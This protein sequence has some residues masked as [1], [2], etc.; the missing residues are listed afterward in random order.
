M[1]IINTKYYDGFEGEGEIQF[2]RVLSNGNRKILSLWYAYFEIIMNSTIPINFNLDKLNEFEYLYIKREGWYDE[3]PWQILDID[4]VINQLKKF[5][6]NNLEYDEKM[7]LK[8]ILNKI[9]KVIKEIRQFLIEA[10]EL[11]EKVYIAY[12]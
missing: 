7:K 3:S 5:D 12:E 6:I 2:I 10:K 8:R 1:D 4:S 9:P 11:N